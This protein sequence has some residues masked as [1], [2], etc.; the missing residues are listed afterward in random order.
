MC[1]PCGRGE[2]SI[3]DDVYA[4]GVAL[5][6]L[7]LARN[8]LAGLDE[9]AVLQRK[10]ALGSY[11][12]LTGGD[13]LPPAISD[14]VRGMLAEDPEHRPTPALLADPASARGRRVAARPQRRAQR[15]LEL[16][17]IEAWDARVLAFA[18]ARHPERALP[19]IRSGTLDVWLR[20]SLGDA[21]LAA[22]LNEAREQPADPPPKEARAEAILATT[23]LVALLD[24]LA[25]LCWQGAAWWPDGLGPALAAARA[26]D[27]EMAG[28]LA[29]SLSVEAAGAWAAVRR[30]RCDEATFR[31]EARQHR[32]L[33][34]DRGPAG[35][36]TGSSTR[37]IRC[38]R[39]AVPCCRGALSRAS[40]TSCPRS[41]RSR[42]RW[43]ARPRVRSMRIPPLSS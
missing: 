7:A 15:P 8:P 40:P 10:L 6:V 39:A 11:E 2:G 26:A 9:A 38:C 25:P 13:R 35:G 21:A 30:E 31:V 41:K 28:K 23:R 3:A 16:G 18:I 17:G 19:A 34:R 32:T 5:I 42:P 33:L 24:P 27:P 37:S 29:E 36:L 4:L 20:R 1:L 43:T 14:L 12:A 22:R